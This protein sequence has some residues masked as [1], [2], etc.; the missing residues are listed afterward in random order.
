MG[1]KKGV[2]LGE[3]KIKF[4]IGEFIHILGWF[5]AKKFKPHPKWIKPH[6]KHA[7][8][9]HPYIPIKKPGAMP[10]SVYKS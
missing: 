5:E 9:T 8:H 6:P 2:K 10:G 7:T 1:M 4:L 3:S